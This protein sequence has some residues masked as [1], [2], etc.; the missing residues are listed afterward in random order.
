MNAPPMITQTFS[1][2]FSL[3]LVRGLVIMS[4]LNDHT[5][6]INSL[7]IRWFDLVVIKAKEVKFSLTSFCI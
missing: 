6:S 1:A 3:L 4:R 7:S 2:K 5:S